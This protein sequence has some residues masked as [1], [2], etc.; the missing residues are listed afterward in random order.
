MKYNIASCRKT[1]DG[2]HFESKA[3]S[4]MNQN[5]NIE[6]KISSYVDNCYRYNNSDKNLN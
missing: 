3:E 2:L 5:K 6:I 1:T 4:K